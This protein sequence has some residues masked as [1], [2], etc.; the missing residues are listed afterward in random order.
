MRDV[1][2]VAFSQSLSKRREADRN[3]VEILIPVIHELRT[4]AGITNED[5]D[6]VCSGS[7]DYLAGQSFAFVSGLDAVGAWPP[8]CESHVEMDGAWALY[9]AWVKIQMGYADLALVYGF[10]KPSM[11][12]LPLTM[13][14]QL[15]PY[16]V[17]PLWPDA[18]SIAALQARLL[19]DGGLLSERDMAEV[20]VRDRAHAKENP[21]A[22]V[23]GDFGVDQILA[24]PYLVS[25]LRKHDCSPISD[26]AS[27][28]L[29]AAGDRA[30]QLCKRP[31]WIRG[32]E[33][34]CE[35]QDLGV[36][37]LT[38]SRS[39]EI[40]AE[41][42]GLGAGKVDVAELSAPFTHQE[43]LVERALG[44]GTETRVNPSGGALA[45]NPIM[46][47][48]LS[49]IGEAAR[50]VWDGSADRAVAHATSGPCLQQNLVCVLEG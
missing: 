49:R 6:F 12:D 21:F 42:A 26:G 24:D 46:A 50:R 32:I 13:A 48:G 7:S 16:S 35:P 39:V 37:D 8:V 43:I 38:R 5:L 11:G 44:L 19:L 45:G 34:I 27:A 20:A 2:V 40:A 14:L 25:P 41:K 36:R 29:L 15:D 1:A 22:Q 23:K 4:N 31:A 10:G 28:V 30:K 9:E 47:V 18:V 33:H 17:M 3:E